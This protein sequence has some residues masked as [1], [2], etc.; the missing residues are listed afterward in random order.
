MERST[1][2]GWPRVAMCT[3]LNEVTFPANLPDKLR[4][5][6]GISLLRYFWRHD[7]LRRG[8]KYWK[9]MMA[10]CW[11]PIH[12]VL[13]AT[14]TQKIIVDD[15]VRSIS[16]GGGDMMWFYL[17]VVLLVLIHL[18]S[19]GLFRWAD[20]VQTRNRGRTGGIRQPYRHN[21]LS[22]FMHMEH[23]E[24]WVASE[25]HWL[26]SMIFDANAIT[27]EAYFE[28]F[29]IAQAFV[30]LGCSLLLI[31]L[32]SFEAGMVQ[33]LW[34]VLLIVSVVPVSILTVWTRRHFTWKMV[35]HRKL[36]ESAWFRSCTWI[37]SNWRQF[38]GMLSSERCALEERILKQNNA[39]VPNHWNR[40]DTAN[41]TEA[42]VEWFTEVCYCFVLLF[43]ALAVIEYEA[44]GLGKM[45]I[46]TYYA[47]LKLCSSTGKSTIK[48][49]ASS[50]RI[51]QALVSLREVAALL[52]QK[53]QR[54]LREEA[55]L[56]AACL[57]R[58]ESPQL[59]SELRGDNA[60]SAAP[61]PRP[62]EAAPPA[63]PLPN[64]L[65]PGTA[66]EPAPA[67]SS[68]AKGMPARGAVQDADSGG[69]NLDGCKDC[70]KIVLEAGA[71]FIRPA[72][73]KLGM[74][75]RDVRLEAAI[76]VP[77]G[78][79][80]HMTASSEG[81]LTSTLGLMA[82]VV[83]VTQPD[84][85]VC[86][87]IPGVRVP[88]GLRCVMLA[89]GHAGLGATAPTVEDHLS[90][91]GAPSDLCAAL[92]R[93]AG[94]IP[95]RETNVLGTGVAQVFALVR[96]MLIDPDVLCMIKP[97]ALVPCDMQ[98]RMRTLL[99]AWQSGGGL[100]HLAELLGVPYDL[101]PTRSAD[102]VAEGGVLYY[103]SAARTLIVGNEIWD[104]PEKDQII[105]IDAYLYTGN[106]SS[107]I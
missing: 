54:S 15:A 44:Y 78:R 88:Y 25:G 60:L 52:N 96:A 71:R 1:A 11:M 87:R 73:S 56:W 24:H 101:G 8:E 90:F 35:L 94:L 104:D 18:L 31:F 82:G 23:S 42:V 16:R 59:P 27:N 38:Y 67:V 95:E 100:P 86:G 29:R 20:V 57:A 62:L 28:Q 85:E 37:V 103:R 105:N 68:P 2:V 53:D 76:D 92:A 89:G 21:L 98:H 4:G 6:K 43:G 91:T 99:R 61:A 69:E 79:L 55:K 97:L 36:D 13:V 47:I 40:R 93:A 32:F 14:L 3:L 77:L 19:A 106:A 81:V 17:E 9:T 74:T 46:G 48:L 84:G 34:Y 41:D 12:P 65:A 64:K 26:Y 45:T 75:F 51:Q 66:Q 72:E 7:R 22:K 33:S 30:G 63:P 80:V 39:F 70:G 107:L 49:T 10:M 102:E 5:G 50:V 83:H 58:P